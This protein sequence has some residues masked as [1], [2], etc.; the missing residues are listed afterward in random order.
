M[1][2]RVCVGGCVSAPSQSCLTLT[3]TTPWTVAH[4]APPSI[5]FSRQEYWSGVLFPPPGVSS[6]S[7]IRTWVSCIEGRYF[8]LW[9]MRDAHSTVQSLSRVRLFATLWITARQASLSIT[10]SRSLP[11]LM[12]IEL[13]MPANRLQPLSSPS[14]PALNLSQYQGLFQ[15]V[16]CLHQ[17]A[18]VLDVIV[19]ECNYV[20]CSVH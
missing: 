4:Q 8:T 5:G 10:N 9:T 20:K 19:R 13:V 2:A 3:F 16:G 11:K 17:V 6:R 18:K 14:P 12:P 1:S 15:W 7:R